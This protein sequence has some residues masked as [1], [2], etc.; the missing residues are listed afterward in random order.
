MDDDSATTLAA[1][2]NEFLVLDSMP[3]MQRVGDSNVSAF[4][5][6]GSTLI[7]LDGASEQRAKQAA[8]DHREELAHG[9]HISERYKVIGEIARGGMGAVLEVQDSD[10][11]RR[12]AMK[13]LLRDTRQKESDTGSPMDTGPVN[14]FIGE[15]QLTGWLEHPNIVPVHELGLDSEGRVYF[16]MKRVKG[17]S[18]R[19]IMDKLRQ[20]HAATHAEF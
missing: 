1:E 2:D 17:R 13:V 14:R 9:H 4:F 6:G 7:D 8:E 11:D 20:G 16:T 15:A 12:V 3:S 18:L 19:Q 10:L 5:E